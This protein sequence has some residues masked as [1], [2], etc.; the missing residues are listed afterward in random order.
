[1]RECAPP[2]TPIPNKPTLTAT[3]VSSS[4]IDLLWRKVP[5]A[6]TY[7]LYDGAEK[8]IKEN[9][10][11]TVYSHIGLLGSTTYTYTLKVCNSS[12]CSEASEAVSATTS[13]NFIVT[14]IPKTIP[15]AYSV[16]QM[17]LKVAKRFH[18]IAF[19][20]SASEPLTNYRLA[21]KKSTDAAP[22]I[23]DMTTKTIIKRNIGKTPIHILLHYDINST[24][25]TTYNTGSSTIQTGAAVDAVLLKSGETYTLFGMKNDGTEVINLGNFSTDVFDKDATYNGGVGL[26]KTF[27][28]ILDGFY[29]VTPSVGGDYSFSC[30][31]DEPIIFPLIDDISMQNAGEIITKMTENAGVFPNLPVSL[32][33]VTAER[34]TY[35]DVFNSSEHA[36]R[37]GE[38]QNA[39]KALE[40]SLQKNGKYINDLADGNLEILE[41]SGYPIAKEHRHVGD[42]PAPEWLHVEILHGGGFTFEVANVP[43]HWGYLIAYAEASDLEKNPNNWVKLWSPVPY[44]EFESGFKSGVKY[45]FAACAVGSSFKLAWVRGNEEL[46]AQ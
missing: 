45:K 12:G 23:T 5:N 28:P 24:I 40:V 17:D 36:G 18:Y 21:L 38:L 33:Q 16:L 13:T 31:E 11:D 27:D 41:K 30:R 29:H 9:I 10:T 7:N 1:M 19:S 25:A 3:P 37:T 4:Q 34:N 6:T 43:N 8:P 35:R 32:T 20:I 44:S 14:E 22:S 2:P 39:R 15:D 26:I 46:I 42:L